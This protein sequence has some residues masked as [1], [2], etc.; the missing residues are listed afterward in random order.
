MILDKSLNNLVKASPFCLH[1]F[2]GPVAIYVYM[3]IYHYHVTLNFPDSLTI[4]PY[5]PSLPASLLDYILYP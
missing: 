5:H 2:Q 4:R 3:D 1:T